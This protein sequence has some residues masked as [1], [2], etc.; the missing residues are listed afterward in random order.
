MAFLTETQLQTIGFSSVGESVLISDRASIYG[1]GRIRIGDHVR[2]DDYSILSAG[3]EGIS[4]GNY[5]HIS[6][7]A[8]LIGKAAISIGDFSALS[9]RASIFSSNDDYSGNY[10]T[11]PTVPTE[12]TN[13][14]HRPVEIRRHCTIGAGAIILPG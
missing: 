12:F 9:V 7:Y 13:V 1:A 8:S 6:C 4:L 10:M 2:I 3:A 11:N 5:I 14:E